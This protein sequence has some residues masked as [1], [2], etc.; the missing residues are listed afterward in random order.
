MLYITLFIFY[1]LFVILFA[2]LR[3]VEI[4]LQKMQYKCTKLL[5]YDKWKKSRVNFMAKCCLLSS[6]LYSNPKSFLYLKSFKKIHLIHAKTFFG[7]TKIF[8]YVAKC[9][10]YDI[11]ALRSTVDIDDIM[12]TY[13]NNM[14][15]TNSGGIH[16]GY[17]RQAMNI[18][19]VLPKL[20]NKIR[21]TGHSLGGS[22][23]TILGYILSGDPGKKINVYTFG[24]PKSGDSTFCH[25]MKQRK[26]FKIE[27]I[28]N[29]FDRFCN[30]PKKYDHI[31]ETKKYNHNTGSIVKNHSIYTYLKISNE[32]DPIVQYKSSIIEKIL[33]NFIHFF[34]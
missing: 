27:N 34:I 25:K 5:K 11:I 2:I 1:F 3:S 32:D 16:S 13:D 10:N 18:L 17:Y 24:S 8:G 30:L 26:N 14:M 4:I 33:I 6:A 9:K 31:G 7:R 19:K 22:L 15:Y 28:V 20:S 23:V 12:T 29:N 21:L